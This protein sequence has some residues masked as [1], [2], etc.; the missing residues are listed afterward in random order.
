M[1]NFS[2]GSM[3]N[4]VNFRRFENVQIPNDFFFAEM[5]AHYAVRCDWCAAEFS[6]GDGNDLYRHYL[7]HLAW[8]VGC[9]LQYEEACRRFGSR[10]DIEDCGLVEVFAVCSCLI[11]GCDLYERHDEGL[12]GPGF[13]ARHLN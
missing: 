6:R 3:L 12:D 4:N 10:M 5:D 8:S 1:L 13:F 7:N 11:P 9:K 2:L